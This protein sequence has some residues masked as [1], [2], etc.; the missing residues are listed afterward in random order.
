[1]SEG[2]VNKFLR[3]SMDKNEYKL[4]LD[5]LRGIYKI[6]LR[7]TP[8]LRPYEDDLTQEASSESPKSQFTEAG[9]CRL[10]WSAAEGKMIF[11]FSTSS[12]TGANDQ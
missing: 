2:K 4:F 3:V 8:A 1:M 6:R 12:M 10:A 5:D 7:K 11:I 9:N